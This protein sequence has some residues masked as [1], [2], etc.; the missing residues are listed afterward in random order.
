MV[1]ATTREHGSSSTS[2]DA[3]DRMERL[4]SLAER[5]QAGKVLRNNVSRASHAGWDPPPDR[6]DPIDV[7]IESSEG[8]I[9]KLIP[10]R[11]AR[12]LQTPFT[13]YRG[14][15]AIMAGDLA[16]TPATG[17][18]VQACG[19][20]HLLNFG[21]FATPERRLIFD[22]ND[23]DETLPAPWEWDLKRLVAS[24][25]I[26]ARSQ[27]FS[28][29]EGRAAAASA[30]CSYR[31]HM[32]EYS[33]MPALEAWYSSVEGNRLVKDRE[34]RRFYE[35][36]IRKEQQRDA[37]SEFAKLTHGGKVAPHIKDDLPLV[38]HVEA[39]K[40]PE[41]WVNVRLVLE[42]YRE[43]LPHDRRVLFDR[44]HFCDIAMKVV[45]V[46]SVGTICAIALFL[47]REGDP[48][49][50]QVKEARSSVLE[51]FA[52]KS[53]Y[54]NRGQRVVVG[55]RVMQAA[56]DIFL[57]WTHGD[58]GRHYFVRQL[59]DVKISPV[60]EIMKPQN[61]IRYGAICGWVLARAH[62]R[63]GDAAVLS[64]YMGKSDTFDKAIAEFA[65][66]YANQN[67]RDHAALVAAVRAGRIEVSTEA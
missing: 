67:E 51:P 32:A 2:G 14:A 27:R 4:P 43:S 36:M 9:P 60:I 20:C 21:G 52:G 31:E 57:G 45:G 5:Y 41:F 24:F 56:S 13:F 55:Q 18:R 26:A 66:A 19:D 12:M 39:E 11:Y 16:H 62:A 50:L 40:D 6:R 15:A 59:R 65:V 22:I 17:E 33:E 23:F 29:R 35:R 58:K 3:I 7:L 46:G 44:F 54:E 25:V 63:S 37:A 28:A 10:I 53:V 34:M 1:E 64:G 30:V 42:R 49:F 38:F 8:R 47:A 48:L 61:L